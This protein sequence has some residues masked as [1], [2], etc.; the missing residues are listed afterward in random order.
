MEFITEE[1]ITALALTPE[2]VAGMKTPYETHLA[3]LKQG[4]DNKA[5]EN[6]EGILTGAASKLEEATGVKRT[7]GEKL[8]DYYVRAGSEF[9]T[10]QKTEIETLKTEYQTKLKDFNGGDATKA[11]LAKAKSDLDA[12]QLQLVDY[13]DLKA[14]AGQL[15][16]ITTK[17]KSLEEKQFFQNEK[18]T[19]PDTVN[20]YEADAKW[21]EF[22]KGFNEKWNKEFDDNGVSIAVSKENPH[23]KKPLSELIIADAELSKLMEG[24]KQTGPGAGSTSKELGTTGV[25]L[26]DNPNP[27]DI[28]T[29]INEYLE[30]NSKHPKTSK[31]RTKEFMELNTKVYAELKK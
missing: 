13:E 28:S 7:Q 26:P 11:E 8:A 2:Q 4:W 1:V 23:L 25:V 5:N 6:A 18:P 12:A 20:K 15:D 14:K 27:T 21:N 30:K 17:Y 3:T 16:E 9:L 10:T 19:F 22:L 31:E 24:R 29:A